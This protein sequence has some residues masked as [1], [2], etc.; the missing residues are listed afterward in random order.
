MNNRPTPETDA[1]SFTETNAANALVLASFACKLEQERDEALE[2]IKQ[3]KLEIVRLNGATSHAGGTPLK[4]ALKERDEA[5][6]DAARWE[7]SFDAMERAGAEQARRADE[8]RE[9]ALKAE[10]ERDEAREAVK[11]WQKLCKKLSPY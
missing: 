3:Q 5:R 1:A 4:I 7:S 2:K 8:N 6:E 11:Y 9:W 10:S